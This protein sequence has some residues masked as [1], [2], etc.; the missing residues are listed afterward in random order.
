MNISYVKAD[1]STSQT[2]CRKIADGTIHYRYP[3]G[4]RKCHRILPHRALATCHVLKRPL[5]QW[6]MAVVILAVRALMFTQAHISCSSKSL[7]GNPKPEEIN[8]PGR[9]DRQRKKQGREG[10][11]SILLYL[12]ISG[13]ERQTTEIIHHPWSSTG[14]PLDLDLGRGQQGPG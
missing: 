4:D 3:Y 5:S 2:H 11:G 10:R 12:F 13:S 8:W 6:C 7:A 14:T 1:D 9:K